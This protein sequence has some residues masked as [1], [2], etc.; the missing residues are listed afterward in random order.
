[1]LIPTIQLWPS[2]LQPV[3]IVTFR[4]FLF[5]WQ[6]PDRYFNGEVWYDLRHAT[7]KVCREA[8]EVAR[9]V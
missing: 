6:V 8:L 1:M 5:F 9:A 2:P 4:R 3:K 7:E